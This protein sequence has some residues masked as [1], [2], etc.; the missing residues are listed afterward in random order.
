[1]FILIIL[2]ELSQNSLVN[3][4]FG[5]NIFDVVSSSGVKYF[6]FKVMKKL[7]RVEIKSVVGGDSTE[8]SIDGGD[9]A[10]CP[11][12]ATWTS[13]PVLCPNGNHWGCQTGNYSWKCC[14]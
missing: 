12:C 2:R 9:G 13:L 1:M 7:S 14:E 10:S 8:E 5:F 11:E 6:Y 4:A 3:V